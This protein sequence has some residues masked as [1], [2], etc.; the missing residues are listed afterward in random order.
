MK[1]ML[2]DGAIASHKNDAVE[3]VIWKLLHLYFECRAI[4]LPG[5]ASMFRAC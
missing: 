1:A 5:F 4:C 3:R 2:N